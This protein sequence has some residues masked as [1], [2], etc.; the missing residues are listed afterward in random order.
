M[1]EL[2]LC[3]SIDDTIQ[4][5]KSGDSNVHPVNLILSNTL[6]WRIHIVSIYEIGIHY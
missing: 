3:L 5:G 4:V 1:L 6:L 2:Q